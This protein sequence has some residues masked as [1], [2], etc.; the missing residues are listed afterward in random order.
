VTDAA[1]IIHA[2]DDPVQIG[3]R[4]PGETGAS[5]TG[6]E[7]VVQW[8]VVAGEGGKKL[9]EVFRRF[10]PIRTPVDSPM[11]RYHDRMMR[12][13]SELLPEMDNVRKPG[14][15]MIFI[16][17][18]M[19]SIEAARKADTRH[20][21]IMGVT[22]LFI[23][24][25]GMMLIYIVQSYRSA[26]TSLSRIRAFSDKL[27][28]SM[29]IGLIALDHD[30]KIVSVNHAGSKILDISPVS[31]VGKPAGDVLP[32]DLYR[33]ITPFPKSNVAL[34]GEVDCALGHGKSIPME[35]SLSGLNDETGASNGS[36]LLLKD[37]SDV[38]ALQKEIVRNQRL[39]SVG[40]LAAG[41][42]HEV[43][44]PLSSIKGFA[45]YFKQKYLDVAED[46]QIATIMIQ[47]VDR[48]NRVV[49]QL[50]ELARPVSVNVRTVAAHPLVEGSLKLAE[51]RAREKNIET[52]LHLSPMADTISAD[53]D[54][55]SQ[56]LLN[57]YLNA[58][59]A[60]KSGGTLSVDLDR[61]PGS[62]G[63]WIRVAD[64][65]SGISPEDIPH[66]F[67]PYFTTKP[68]GTGLGLAIALNIV[69]AHNG[70]ITAGSRAGRGTVMSVF[71]PDKSGETDDEP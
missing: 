44:N 67:D 15:L 45:T 57:L 29:P 38:R 25:T 53:P 26:R 69:E 4:H 22:L 62:Q 11:G 5:L 36:L 28:E 51:G 30:E 35:F 49:S 66:V 14:D 1:G 6:P 20:A 58:I 7:E 3:R 64:T 60:M 54:R 33:R 31:A 23:G 13:W 39:A 46:Q 10:S 56:V 55:L 37:L 61:D 47:E 40:K 19:S 42:A 9:F 21:I 52:K 12:R 17:L 68:N 32:P 27:V 63:A 65:G 48:L 8:R 41:V 2:A 34:E 71:L 18:D 43:R 24:F 59:D 50:L 16:G 70:Q